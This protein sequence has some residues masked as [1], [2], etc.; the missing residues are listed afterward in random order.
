MNARL[1][2]RILGQQMLKLNL[3][4][5]FPIQLL[6]EIQGILIVGL[7][8]LSFSNFFSKGEA[9]IYGSISKISRGKICE[10]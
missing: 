10:E 3:L 5:L 9:L 2:M 7:L 1:L 4:Q 8:N 6:K